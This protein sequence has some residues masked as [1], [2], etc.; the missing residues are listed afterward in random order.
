MMGKESVMDETAA[1][2]VTSSIDEDVCG[3]LLSSE[4]GG[5]LAVALLSEEFGRYV[6]Y[7]LETP[8]RAS[9]DATSCSGVFGCDGTRCSVR[10][11]GGDTTTAATLVRTPGEELEVRAAWATKYG[12]VKIATPCRLVAPSSTDDSSLL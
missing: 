11:F 5:A 2:R 3:G 4:R 8:L 6:E 1:L 7:V 12:R 9:F 10:R